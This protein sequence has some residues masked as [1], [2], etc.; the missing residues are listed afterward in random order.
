VSTVK[1]THQN[2]VDSEIFKSWFKE[3]SEAFLSHFFC[4]VKA[5]F[6][7]NSNWEIGYFNP[8]NQKIT[9]F[10]K[11]ESSFIVKQEDDVFKKKTTTVEKLEIEKVEKSFDE[12]VKFCKKKIKELFPHESLRDGFVILQTFENKTQWNFTFVTQSLK[13]ANIKID[14][15]TGEICSHQLVEAVQREK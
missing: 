4:A 3:H 5:S 2:L 12:M 7:K 6:E 11:T 9:I 8:D 14:A 10:V 1:E 15:N 13:F